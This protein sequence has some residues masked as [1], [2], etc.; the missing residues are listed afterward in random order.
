MRAQALEIGAT[1][2]SRLEL[3]GNGR[4]D[5]LETGNPR[6]KNCALNLLLPNDFASRDCVDLSQ[7]SADLTES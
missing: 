1:M 3:P 2:R 6:G 5:L 4:G 7:R